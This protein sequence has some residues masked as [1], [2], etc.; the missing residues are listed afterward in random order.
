VLKEGGTARISLLTPEDT[1][2]VE[3]FYE[4]LSHTTMSIIKSST[5]AYRNRGRDA[6]NYQSYLFLSALADNVVLG[7]KAT[8]KSGTEQLS[9]ISFYLRPRDRKRDRLCMPYGTVVADEFQGKGMGVALKKAQIECAK[10]DGMVAM[11][12]SD[13]TQNTVKVWR[14]ATAELGLRFTETTTN[15]WC[16]PVQDYRIDFGEST[17]RH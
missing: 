7:I 2:D 6:S 4:R 16:G 13:M 11:V 5:C 10:L 3:R 15:S 17:I 8:G 12:N 9:A 14:K 1:K